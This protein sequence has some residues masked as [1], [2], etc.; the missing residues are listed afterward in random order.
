MAGESANSMLARSNLQAAIAH[1]TSDQVSLEL[2][3]VLREPQRS[4]RDGVLVT[5]T[6]VKVSPAPERRVIGNLRDQA[7]LHEG[8]GF[9][10]Q[11][12]R[13]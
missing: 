10:V 9:P 11:T 13:E 4:L 12:P 3:D 1:L 5:P 7:A 2:I 6:L 8:L